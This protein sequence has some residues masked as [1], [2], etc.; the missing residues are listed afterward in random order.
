LNQALSNT[1]GNNEGN[2]DK[3]QTQLA[4]KKGKQA[5]KMGMRD[6]IKTQRQVLIP[7]AP[8]SANL[9]PEHPTISKRKAPVTG[10]TG[11]GG[12]TPDM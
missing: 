12:N 11:D 1:T 7:M 6:E 4:E 9:L 5:N 2:T 8:G 10:A 3:G